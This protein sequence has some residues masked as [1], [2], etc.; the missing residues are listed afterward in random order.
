MS[1]PKNEYGWIT[2]D[3]K[4]FWFVMVDESGHA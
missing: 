1:P 2:K 3:G 4:Q